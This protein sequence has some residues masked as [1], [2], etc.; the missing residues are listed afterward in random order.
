MF[1][2]DKCKY[3]DFRNIKNLE[4]YLLFMAAGL[5]KDKTR[6]KSPVNVYIFGNPLLCLKQDEFQTT[7]TDEKKI[8]KII[9]KLV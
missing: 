1:Y 9:S 2:D 3:I 6:E 8:V 7:Q 5:L 4:V